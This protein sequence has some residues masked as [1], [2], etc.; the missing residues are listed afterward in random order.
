MMYWPR[1]ALSRALVFLSE[2]IVGMAETVAPEE[3]KRLR[4]R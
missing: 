4:R 1:Y 3:V 2:V